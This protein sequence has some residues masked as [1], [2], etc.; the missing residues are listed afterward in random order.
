[1]RLQ[2]YLAACGVASRRHA[3][4]MIAKGDVQVNGITV[5]EMGTQVTEADEVRV[6]GEVVSLEENKHY[7]LY[8]K[9]IGEVTTSSDPQ[10]RPT[11]LDHF[12]D[13][14]VRLYTVGRLDFD[15]EGLLL[16]TNDG[17]LTARLTHPSFEVDKSYI[18]RV[19]LELTDDECQQLRSGILLDGRRT[20]RAG[21]RVLKKELLFTDVLITIHEGRNRQ[22]RRMIESVGHQVL[23]LKRVKYGPIELGSIAR[24]T[25]REL[26]RGEVEAL[27]RV[28]KSTRK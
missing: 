10:G 23:R 19:S 1:M 25:W 11:V 20:A 16:L 12:G 3:E 28:A 13:F 8:Y 26:S 14:P 24:G 9:P 21:V 4:E 18:A 27:S 7:V 17:D 5:R 15:S 2:K 6:H 22:I